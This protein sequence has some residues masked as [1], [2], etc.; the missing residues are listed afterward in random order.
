MPLW[1]A[2]DNEVLTS[3]RPVEVISGAMTDG[4][5]TQAVALPTRSDHKGIDVVFFVKFAGNPGGTVSYSLQVALSNV[6][7]EFFIVGSAMTNSETV[8]GLVIVTSIVARFARV[9]ATDADSENPT[10]S[11]MVM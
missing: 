3:F 10:I 2:A 5:K 6:D 9:I 11:L 8:G 4:Q 7:A 1:N